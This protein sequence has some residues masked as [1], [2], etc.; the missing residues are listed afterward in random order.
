MTL[1]IDRVP[2]EDCPDHYEA[3]MRAAW[4]AGATASVVAG[5][6]RLTSD[7][8]G[9]S[10]AIQVTG[11]SANGVVGFSTTEVQGTGDP[12]TVSTKSVSSLTVS[13]PATAD[14]LDVLIIGQLKGQL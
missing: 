4:V 11:G 6:V 2:I 9:P 10:G 13:G 1:P 5:T 14:S 7:T 8:F 12:G 3:G